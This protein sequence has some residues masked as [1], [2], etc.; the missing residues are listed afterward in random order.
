MLVDTQTLTDSWG[1]CDLSYVLCISTSISRLAHVFAWLKTIKNFE[2]HEKST[3]FVMCTRG[4]CKA[5]EEKKFVGQR[6]GVTPKNWLAPKSW[7]LIL[8][9]VVFDYFST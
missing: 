6:L 4:L 3:F 5:L 7:L 1:K 8:N 9:F 2:N